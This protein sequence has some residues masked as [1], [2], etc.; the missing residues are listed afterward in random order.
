MSDQ[1]EGKAVVLDFPKDRRLR[2]ASMT[3][4][5]PAIMTLDGLNI[6]PSVVFDFQKKPITELEAHELVQSIKDKGGVLGQHHFFIPWPCAAV[7]FEIVE[8]QLQPQPGEER[9]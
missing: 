6:S 3:F 4:Y 7:H 2:I 8:A 1:T 9:T 5:G